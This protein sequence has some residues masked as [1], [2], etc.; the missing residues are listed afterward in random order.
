MLSFVLSE[1]PIIP[2]PTD[3][4]MPDPMPDPIPYPEMPD[5]DPPELLLMSASAIMTNDFT[6]YGDPLAN[7]REAFAPLREGDLETV[8]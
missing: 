8:W 4:L 1:A 5:P 2:D 7:F 6:E 3:P